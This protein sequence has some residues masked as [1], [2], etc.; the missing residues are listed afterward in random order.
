MATKAVT[1]TDI[2]LTQDGS[3]KLLTWAALTQATLDDGV[4]MSF[5][6]FGDVCIQMT[7]TLGAGGTV[8]WEGTNDTTTSWATLNNAQGSALS[9]TALGIKQCV[10]RPL[11]MRPRCTAGDGTTSLVVTALIR[12]IN[13]MRT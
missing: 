13:T 8:V 5:P 2:S 11:W 7:G 12:R 9:L 4:P 10:E 6:E 3:V 1:I